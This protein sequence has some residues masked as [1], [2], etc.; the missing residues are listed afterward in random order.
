MNRYV[1]KNHDAE[2]GKIVFAGSSLME[3][4][5]LEQ[6]FLDKEIIV[7]NRGISGAT[8][9]DYLEIFDRLILSIQ[10]V[11]LLINI[12][13]NDLADECFEDSHLLDSYRQ[14]FSKLK[15]SLPQCAVT[16]IKFYPVNTGIM[17]D[18]SKKQGEQ[19]LLQ[20]SKYRINSRVIEAS[21]KNQQACRFKWI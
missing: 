1:S 17:Q 2:N 13:S 11:H 19:W 12:G 10:P 8:S 6:L 7:Y 14:I 4:F 18:V 3:E 15:K 5:P 21:E 20:A 16:F 9:K